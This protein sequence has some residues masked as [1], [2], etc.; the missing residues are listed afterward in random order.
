MSYPNVNV[1]EMWTVQVDGAKKVL[2][3]VRLEF[4]LFDGFLSN[5]IKL[6]AN[7]NN[8]FKSFVSNF[9]AWLTLSLIWQLNEHLKSN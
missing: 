8:C 5:H 7:E 3:I 6:C 1:Y 4:E 9:S 2:V